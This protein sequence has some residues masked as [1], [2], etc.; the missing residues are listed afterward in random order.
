MKQEHVQTDDM[1]GKRA[2]QLPASTQFAIVKCL[3]NVPY[4]SNW[5]FAPFQ[6][7][8]DKY[9]QLCKDKNI[10][11][12]KVSN[13]CIIEV[14]PMYLLKA[15]DSVQRGIVKKDDIAKIKVKSAEARVSL[16]KF[17][18]SKA[19]K[20]N[21]EGIIGIYCTNASTSI[22]IKGVNYPSFRVNIQTALKVLAEQGYRVFVKGAGYV[23]AQQAVGAI[24]QVFEGMA[25]SPTDTG[26][27][28]KIAK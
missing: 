1:L 18:K 19:K 3:G 8:K 27:F 21:F 4:G 17:L 5:G 14:N 23:P 28:L 12:R 16:E 24:A 25:V 20:G 22:T 2:Q 11:A 13:G 26:A 6:E 15:A 9:E 7:I 10:I